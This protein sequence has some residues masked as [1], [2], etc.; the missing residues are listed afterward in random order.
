VES[1]AIHHL[2]RP[3]QAPRTSGRGED[4]TGTGQCTAEAP[5]SKVTAD[6]AYDTWECRYEV[7]L[8]DA[9]ATIPPRENAV[10][11]GCADVPPV[12]ERDQAI[13][14]IKQTGLKDWKQQTG[15]GQRSLAETTMFRVKPT[16]GERMK[17]RVI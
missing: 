13:A 6:G 10:V 2:E 17:A 12:A 7:H 3:W 9:E 16:F 8:R 15:D 5:A 14:Q 1:S 11:V 4:T